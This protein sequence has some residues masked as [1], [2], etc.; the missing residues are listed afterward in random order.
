MSTFGLGSLSLSPAHHRSQ[1]LVSSLKG[2]LR[3]PRKTRVVNDITT[4]YP[5]IDQSLIESIIADFENINLPA[6]SQS[7]ID[8]CITKLKTLNLISGTDSDTDDAYPRKARS[9]VGRNTIPARQKLSPYQKRAPRSKSPPVTLP[10][11]PSTFAPT[12][13]SSSPLSRRGK[14]AESPRRKIVG[15]R[16]GGDPDTCTKVSLDAKGFSSPCLLSNITSPDHRVRFYHGQPPATLEALSREALRAATEDQYIDAPYPDINYHLR[17]AVWSPE[18]YAS[19]DTSSSSSDS[20]SD[21]DPLLGNDDLGM[22]VDGMDWQAPMWVPTISYNGNLYLPAY[23]T[24]RA[25][26]ARLKAT[27]LGD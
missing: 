25:L 14:D 18:D 1:H 17:P 5:N 9:R 12:Y 26:L 8:A 11:D 20:D 7:C 21:S 16:L 24:D 27:W 2:G 10:K 22:D 19:S 3:P 4:K 23:E 15:S 6:S 13:N